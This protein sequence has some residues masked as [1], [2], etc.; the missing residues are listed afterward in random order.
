M[1]TEKNPFSAVSPE[2]LVDLA[3]ALWPDHSRKEMAQVTGGA[4]KREK[5][6]S[7]FYCEYCCKTIHLG[8]VYSLERAKKEHNA[9]FHPG[10]R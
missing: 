2:E 6:V 3:L 1:K 8:T 9:K 7:A 4:K 5:F 10:V